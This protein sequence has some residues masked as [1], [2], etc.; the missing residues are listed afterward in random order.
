MRK[1]SATVVA[2]VEDQ[3]PGLSLQDQARL[4]TPF[5]GPCPPSGRKP[6]AGL[7]LVI[8]KYMAEAMGGNIWVDAAPRAGAAFQ[9]D[10]PAAG[11]KEV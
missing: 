1:S 11:T 5:P 2:S 7:G 10:F 9:V 8:V 4:L 6:L 3:G